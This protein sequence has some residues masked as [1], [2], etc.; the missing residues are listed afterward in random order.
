MKRPPDRTEMAGRAS[1]PTQAGAEVEAAS[2]GYAS[3]DDCGCLLALQ[4]VMQHHCCKA[5]SNELLH[6][7]L[8]EGH[9]LR[10]RKEICW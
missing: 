3:A 5:L 8:C 7:R 9:V 1:F 4:K 10:H 6:N 2:E